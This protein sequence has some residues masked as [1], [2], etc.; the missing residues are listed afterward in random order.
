[1][2]IV[3]GSATFFDAFDALLIA[4]VLPVLI[5]L[6]HL[7]PTQ[8]GLLV[9]SGYIG[10]MIGGAVFGWVAERYGRLRALAWSVGV[11]SVMSLA[12]AFAW[13]VNSLMVLRCI[14]GLGLGGEVP[15]ALAYVNEFAKAETRGRFVLIFQSIFPVGILVA[16]L[17][18]IWVVPHWGWQWMFMIGAAPALLIALLLRTL[19]E[20]PRWLA[21][22]GRLQEA[23]RVVSDLEAKISKNGAKPLPPV[24]DAPP[25]PAGKAGSW[26]D[27]FAGIY[28]RRTLMIWV[29]W[30]VASF[31]GFGIA[32]WL[33]TLLR[34][35]YKLPLQEALQYGFIFNIA[36]VAGVLTITYLV[37]RTGRRAGFTAAFV[38]AAA[39]LILLWAMG[40]QISVA[41]I[42]GLAWIAGFFIAMLQLGLFLYAAELYPTRIRALGTGLGSSWTR[43]GAIVGQPIV[44][45]VLL[46]ADVGAV[47][48]ILGA[49][50]LV[51]G[52]AIALFGVE[53][54]GMVLEKLSP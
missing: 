37:D 45:L 12:C 36:P 17:L 10:Q 41:L 2:R 18:S 7:T 4:F 49:A 11:L 22:T 13:D 48:L 19:P 47:F 42:V 38:F 43:I 28:L 21:T 15:I 33:P 31:V 26:R 52:A 16:S 30:F 53:T 39:P 34:T 50:A 23:D 35:V 14:Q 3:V 44:G 1:M 51:G 29:T 32:I 25:V 5:G 46:K 54:R 20:S 6:W 8:I 9:A 27:L 40:A 24:V